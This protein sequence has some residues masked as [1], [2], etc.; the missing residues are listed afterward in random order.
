MAELATETS[1]EPEIIQSEVRTTAES[2]FHIPLLIRE[3]QQPDLTKHNHVM[4]IE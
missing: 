1:P 2:S 3:P 4:M